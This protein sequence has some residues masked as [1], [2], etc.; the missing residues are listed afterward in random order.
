MFKN[1]KEIYL[2][3]K[4]RCRHTNKIYRGISPMFWIY[5]CPDCGK[6]LRYGG[7]I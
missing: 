2:N 5:D 6:V 4:N 1:I 7:R 3:F